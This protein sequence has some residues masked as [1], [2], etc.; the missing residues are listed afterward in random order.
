MIVNS[1]TT[2][3]CSPSTFFQRCILISRLGIGPPSSFLPLYR[4]SISLLHSLSTGASLRLCYYNK[5][6]A[7]QSSTMHQLLLFVTIIECWQIIKPFMHVFVQEKKSCGC[8]HIISLFRET[9]TNYVDSCYTTHLKFDNIEG[10][11]NYDLGYIF[12]NKIKLI[13]RLIITTMS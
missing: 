13:S 7:T 5:L 10:Q 3:Y 12:I 4:G 6:A 1:I 9:D 8:I 11:P 2:K